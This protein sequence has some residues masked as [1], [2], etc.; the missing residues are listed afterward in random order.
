V[1]ALKTD[2]NIF[3]GGLHMKIEKTASE[4]IDSL[5]KNGIATSGP[6]YSFYAP[7]KN[8]LWK[9]KALK[10]IKLVID[11]VN[12]KELKQIL[13]LLEERGLSNDVV[14]LHI[15]ENT[16]TNLPAEIENFV[17]LKKF[18]IG[19]SNL[20]T[21]PPKIGNLN[22]LGKPALRNG[23]L[24]TEY[25]IYDLI[26]AT[27]NGDTKAVID[28]LASGVS[29][30]QTDKHRSP[31]LMFAV[32]LGHRAIAEA[33]IAAGANIDATH[34][35]GET[36]P[37]IQAAEMGQAEMVQLL[38]DHKAN[39]KEINPGAP[40]ALMFAADLG[41]KTMVDAL[42]AAGASATARTLWYAAGKGHETII[43][44]LIAAGAK[45]NG[46]NI[47]GE[48][49]LIYAV[50]G[51][52]TA[53]VAALIAS[54]AEPNIISMDLRR[55][56]LMI[57]ARGGYIEIVKALI[58]A[59]AEVER[60]I[61]GRMTALM[62]AALNGHTAIVKVLIA[63]GANVN[64]TNRDGDTALTIATDEGRA[65][66][67]EV[68]KQAVALQEANR[69]LSL[70][71]SLAF[72]RQELLKATGERN[73]DKLQTLFFQA[74]KLN[75]LSVI[76]FLIDNHGVDINQMDKEVCSVLIKAS[77]NNSL[78]VVELLLHSADIQKEIITPNGKTTIIL[79]LENTKTDAE[80][81]KIMIDT[82]KT[83]TTLDTIYVFWKDTPSEQYAQQL[84]EGL[85]Q[86]KTLSKIVTLN[87]NQSDATKR[88]TEESNTFFQRRHHINEAQKALIQNFL[89]IPLE[90]ITEDT[91]EKEP[92][93]AILALKAMKSLK[94][95]P[96]EVKAL[97]EI[98][99]VWTSILQV[100]EILAHPCPQNRQMGDKYVAAGMRGM[101]LNQGRNPA[102]IENMVG[103]KFLAK[104]TSIHT[105]DVSNNDMGVAGIQALAQ[106]TSIQ[107]LSIRNNSI[108]T[109]GAKILTQNTSIQTLNVSGNYFG[110]AGAKVLAK[111][112]SIQTLDVSNNDISYVGAEALAQNTSIHT[113]NV[114]I[115]HIETPGAEALAQNTSIRT[116]DVSLNNIDEA[117]A[118]ALAQNKSIETLN[119][120]NNSIG[121]AGA[122]FLAK[123]TSIRTLDVSQN[124]IGEAGAQA[125]AQNKSIQSLYVGSNNF[126]RDAGTDAFSVA[127]LSSINQT[128]TSLLGIELTLEVEAMLKLNRER[129]SRPECNIIIETVNPLL[130]TDLTELILAYRGR[131][132]RYA[133]DATVHINYPMVA[134][135][136]PISA[137]TYSKS[138]KSYNLACAITDASEERKFDAEKIKAFLSFLQS[139][140]CT[141]SQSNAA[142]SPT[143]VASSSPISIVTQ[144]SIP[145]LPIAPQ[146]LTPLEMRRVQMLS[147]R[148]K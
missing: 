100:R 140:T 145:V 12:E 139:I 63:G 28:L 36:T 119:I 30:N 25:V 49:A 52:H 3:L 99:D 43:R 24:S 129:A 51:G 88:L 61:F 60:S 123:N 80:G 69:P 26:S 78:D 125:L 109:V 127:L 130:S 44:T 121:D 81:I 1:D 85:K 122:K 148:N 105:L 142:H 45:V 48:T 120:W 32:S 56:A 13:K 137:N 50:K 18:S 124:N 87:N 84:I 141:A 29:A 106:N 86:S 41:N 23:R 132:M 20:I 93:N 31:A 133:L 146:S 66:I 10:P 79:D 104:N 102:E 33:L 17:A 35:D 128:L 101:L 75:W 90:I 107:T 34:R 111:S 144:A 114:S 4:L 70:K 27:K 55:D 65:E 117:G 98:R 53:T 110:D 47:E 64:A 16:L 54:G 94:D 103:T 38:I 19:M 143:T 131:S 83:N 8:Y 97:F 7:L 108:K 22:L 46:T 95:I 15:G 71:E 115:N 77:E 126:R 67:V 58:A 59:G 2:I 72:C 68:L 91:F 134:W 37:I 113:L 11:K 74:V 92:D 57:A 39:L 118:Q 40:T 147:V 6:G 14:S 136:A 82:L 76:K 89:Q 5:E 135:K 9:D 21:L 96:T 112:K 42:I 73:Q 62:F 138:Q 116:L